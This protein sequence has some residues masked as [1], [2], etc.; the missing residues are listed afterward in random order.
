MRIQRTSQVITASAVFFS[1]LTVVCAVVSLRYRTL[2]E[3]NYADR[4]IATAAL[5]QLAAGSDRLTMAVRAYAATAD[6]RDREEFY[7]ELHVDRSRDDAVENLK[8]V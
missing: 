8:Q 1:V 4:R 5:R 6:P 7:R 2:Q 3:A